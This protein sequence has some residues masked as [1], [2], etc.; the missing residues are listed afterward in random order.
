MLSMKSRDIKLGQVGTVKQGLTMSRYLDPRGPKKRVLQIA[1]LVSGEVV[2]RPDDR[3]EQVDEGRAKEL[4]AVPGQVLVS[5][6]GATMKAGVVPDTLTDAVIS[7]SLISID[8]KPEI[9]DPHFLAGLL[10]SQAM[11]WQIQT[12]FTGTS[13]QVLPLSRFK[14]LQISLPPIAQQRKL[15][16][17]MEALNRYERET[18]QMIALRHEELETY[19][20]E[21][22]VKE[23][24]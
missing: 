3:F 8:L 19:L 12:L 18:A 21:Y 6:R 1:N 15:A 16:A 24:G 17:A 7:S 14:G 11:Q 13:V 20:N 10:S 2:A 4:Y 5:L 23:R 22:V 9:A